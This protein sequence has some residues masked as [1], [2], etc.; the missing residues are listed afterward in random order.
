MEGHPA[1]G[2]PTRREGCAL[3][4]DWS[5]VLFGARLADMR[6]VDYR[7][8]LAIASLIELLVQK[9]IVTPDEL[10]DKSRT[11]DTE[12]ERLSQAAPARRRAR[13][14]AGGLRGGA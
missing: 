13:G 9:G 11:L 5:T 10:A 6:D 14:L 2:R 1:L 3:A 12:A 7:N 4:H 8:T